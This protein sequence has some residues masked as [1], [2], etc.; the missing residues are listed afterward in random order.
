M[1]VSGHDI[2][3]YKG[4]RRGLADQLVLIRVGFRRDQRKHRGAVRRRNSY[5]ALSGLKAHIK[6][7]VEPELIYV[8]P[9]AS[10]LIAN[11]NVDR[12]N[13]EVGIIAIQR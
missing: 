13:A 2:F 1:A 11:K 6:G 4:D 7:E 10:V 12:V 5:P 8:E 3:G 9:Q